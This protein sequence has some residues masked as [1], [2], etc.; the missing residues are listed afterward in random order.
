MR[1]RTTGLVAAMAAFTAGILA[2]SAPA[3][4]SAITVISQGHVDAIDVAYEEGE[5]GITIHDETVEPDV[6]R[7]PADV[8]LVARHEAKTTVPD[9]P[10]YA[11][12]GAPGAEV[13]VLP[14]TQ[15]TA[16]LWPGLSAEEVEPGVFVGDSIQIRFKQVLGPDGLSLFTTDPVGAPTVLVDSEDGLPDAVTLPAGAHLH[17]NWA[18]EKAGVYLIKVDATAQLAADGTRVTSAPAWIKFAVLS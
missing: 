7:D 15:D 18:F 6:E 3:Q 5:W 14:E 11:F 1:G 9:D 8:L 4:A 13:W 16:L 2:F 12:L 17:A 10:T